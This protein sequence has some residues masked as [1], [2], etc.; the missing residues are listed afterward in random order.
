VHLGNH[1]ARAKLFLTTKRVYC[2]SPPP[3]IDKVVVKLSSIQK[4]ETGA[5][6]FYAY[7]VI[8]LNAQSQ[9]LHVL[10]F[11]LTY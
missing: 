5:T 6:L 11:P 9:V 3:L 2:Q 10:L 4:V 1:V 7:A 8:I